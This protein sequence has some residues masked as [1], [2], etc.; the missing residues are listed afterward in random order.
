MGSSDVDFEL[1]RDHVEIDVEALA[2]SV[3]TSAT[4]KRL[5][6]ELAADLVRDRLSRDEVFA[7]AKV[8][9]SVGDAYDD[10]PWHDYFRMIV[11][12]AHELRGPDQ[13][14]EGLREVGRCYYRGMTRTPI[15]RMLLGNHLGTVIRQLAENWQRLNTVGKVRS[16]FC[17][18]R[19]F[20]FHFDGH[21]PALVET[22]AVGIF[23]GLLR[24]HYMPETIRLARVGPMNTI[25]DV[26]W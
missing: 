17:S 13:L 5:F 23:E 22:V 26:R 9:P 20:R 11:T 8:D 12:V 4:N 14:G 2:A 24:Y 10:M 25:L 16:E 19:N 21:A 18:E 6:I 3:P 15:G 7:R 1:P